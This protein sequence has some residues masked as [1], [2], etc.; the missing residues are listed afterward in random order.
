MMTKLCFGNWKLNKN[1]EESKLFIDELSV[2]VKSNSLTKQD[3]AIFPPA[4]SAYVFSYQE[5]VFWGGQ[6]V[7][8]E[9]SGAYTGESSLKTLKAMGARYALIGHSERRNL[10]GETDQE[11]NLKTALCIEQKLMPVV[12][13]GEHLND[14]ESGKTFEVL[15]QQLDIGLKNIDVSKIIIA[16]E[17]VWA[18][19]TGKTASAQQ[20]LEVHD[21]LRKELGAVGVNTPLLYGGSVK[22]EN[23]SELY[24]VDNI[25]GFL[26]GG[27]SLSA[28]SFIEIYN[29]MES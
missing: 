10:F 3:F 8:F 4:L 9:T 7:Y 18:I 22:P 29:N 24:S 16:Y 6:N 15:K 5:D 2:Y 12:C 21:W 1:P 19:G 27:A 11:V 28:K 17:P 13:I 20:A 26:I 14:R 25:N 23:S